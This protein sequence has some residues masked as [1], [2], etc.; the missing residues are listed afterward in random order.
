MLRQVELLLW[1]GPRGGEATV[2]PLAEGDRGQ[3]SIQVQEPPEGFHS[4][5]PVCLAY[6]PHI[7]QQ[8]LEH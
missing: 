1:D 2:L 7:L 6:W 8:T 3:W 4:A 5:V